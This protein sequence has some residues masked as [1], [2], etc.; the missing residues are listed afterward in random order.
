VTSVK[1]SP[2]KASAQS[3]VDKAK[4]ATSELSDT[5]G[6]L[7]APGTE[8]GKT[9]KSTVDE[10]GK[11]LSSGV[12]TIQSDVKNASSGVA[13]ALDAVSKV[14]G[15]LATMSSQVKTAVDTLTSLPS[16]ELSQAFKDA[17]ACKTLRESGSSS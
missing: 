7:G 15:T 3:A 13:G 14:S 4:Q 2:S 16:G 6:G 1:S 5:L 10:L 9:A 17:P 12:D 11:Q 8:A